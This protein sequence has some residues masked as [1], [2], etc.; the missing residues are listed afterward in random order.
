MGGEIPAPVKVLCPSLGEFQDRDAGVGR[1]VSRGRGNGIWVF[2]R[3][4]EETK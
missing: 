4:N 3:G 2:W 1:L